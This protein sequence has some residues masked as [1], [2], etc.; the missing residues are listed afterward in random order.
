MRLPNGDDEWPPGKPI[1]Q[2]DVNHRDDCFTATRREPHFE[3]KKHLRRGFRVGRVKSMLFFLSLKLVPRN[4]NF[5]RKSNEIA[6]N[7]L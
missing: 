4:L 1:L 2:N 5:T 3:K 7:R 6:I